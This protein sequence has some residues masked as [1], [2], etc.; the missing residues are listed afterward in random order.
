[1]PCDAICHH[2]GVQGGRVVRGVG[3]R[4]AVGVDRA[5]R[6]VPSPLYE[7]SR[8]VPAGALCHWYHSM[9]LP[10]SGEVTGVW[11]LRGRVD[12]YLGNAD[13]AGKRVLEIGPASGFLT[14]EMERRG[15]EVVCVELPKGSSFDLVPFAGLDLESVRRDQGETLQY[16]QNGFWRAHAE[17]ESSARV[18]H[19]DAQGLPERLGTFDTSVIASVLQHLHD[20]VGV[21]RACAARTTGTLVVTDLDGSAMTDLD[22]SAMSEGHIDGPVLELFPSVERPTPFTWWLLRPRL[23]EVLFDI[24][25]FTDVTTTYHDDPFVAEDRLLRSFT[26]VGHRLSGR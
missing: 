7:K 24:L 12:E 11:D 25:G 16:M 6:L 14:F 18:H 9:T 2:V 22:D 8:I 21:V 1:M 13:F 26:V 17:L 23:F 15:A 19:G 3:R 4:V 20:P 5:R 10:E